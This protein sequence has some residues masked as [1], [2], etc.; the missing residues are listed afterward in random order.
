MALSNAP[1]NS[2]PRRA[3]GTEDNAAALS[4]VPQENRT[5][6]SGQMMYYQ[7]TGQ[8]HSLSTEIVVPAIAF[9]PPESE[10]TSLRRARHGFPSPI[11]GTPSGAQKSLLPPSEQ[12]VGAQRRRLLR[13][14]A[15]GD[16]RASRPPRPRSSTVTSSSPIGVLTAVRFDRRATKILRRPLAFQDWRLRHRR[17]IL[18]CHLE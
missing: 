8:L 2:T 4:S 15:G 18:I 12:D 11:G 5:R 7:K 14:R 3:C 10:S 13:R 16:V 17:Q 6:R 1:P 9:R